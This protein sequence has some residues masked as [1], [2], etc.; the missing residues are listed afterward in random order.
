VDADSAWS[1]DILL[2]VH[3]PSES[4][5]PKMK[6]GGLLIS[7]LEPYLKDGFFEKIAG[8][9][10]SAMSMELIPRT[11]RAQSMDVLSSQ[12]NIAGYRAVLEAATHYGRF[13]PLMMTS[14][15]SSKPA[16]VMILLLAPVLLIAPFIVKV[17][18]AVP[19]AKTA[20]P[21]AAFVLVAVMAKF[22]SEISSATP[23]QRTVL[24]PVLPLGLI[25]IVP[26]VPIEL[27]AP[28]MPSLFT[29]KAPELETFT[30][31]PKELFV[32]VR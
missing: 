12:A 27:F 32:P 5:I 8:Q 24:A 16:K 19:F 9:G 25:V 7:L 29:Y 2:K 11:S 13:L 4:E 20:N 22:L 21:A 10:I 6:K 3:R 23:I 31:P 15:G 14:A 28:A 17:A 1:S 30:P 18:P 26:L